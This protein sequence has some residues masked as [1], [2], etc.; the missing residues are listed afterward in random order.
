MVSIF[1]ADRSLMSITL[2]LPPTASL[3]DCQFSKINSIFCGIYGIELV[4]FKTN[5]L[6]SYFKD[7]YFMYSLKGIDYRIIA[8]T[9]NLDRPKIRRT[10]KRTIVHEQYDPVD[11]W[12]HDIAIVQANFPLIIPISAPLFLVTDAKFCFLGLHSVH[13]VAR[14]R[15][16]NAA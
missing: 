8:G 3:G 16:R 13:A 9:V 14:C 4:K 10:V 1:V 11:S 15:I 5:V 6:I 12:R 7:N 2:L